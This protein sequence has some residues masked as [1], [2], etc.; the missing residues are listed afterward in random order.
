MAARPKTTSG[1]GGKGQ[2]IV[3]NP[4]P[5]PERPRFEGDNPRFNIPA[6]STYMPPMLPFDPNVGQ[7]PPPISTATED[8][9]KVYKGDP[10]GTRGTPQGPEGP[11]GDGTGG[12]KGT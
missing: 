5:M 9:V 10:K 12:P 4:T 1:R 3:R 2:T 11:D 7:P 8:T 6:P